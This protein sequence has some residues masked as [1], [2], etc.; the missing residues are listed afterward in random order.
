MEV[1]LTDREYDVMQVL[2]VQGSATVAEVQGHLSDSLAYTT[3]LTVLRTLADKG[4]VVHS[5][6][7][8][9]HRFHPTVAEQ[10]AQQGATKRLLSRVFSGSP[11]RLLTHLVSDQALSKDQLRRIRTMLDERLAESEGDS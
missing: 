4:F 10:D 9:A 1:V 3:V 8:R 6:E 5:E 7:G 11:E 2:W